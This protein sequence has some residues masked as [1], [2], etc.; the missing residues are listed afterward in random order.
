MKKHLPK[1]LCA[2]FA[3]IFA[4]SAGA[5][6]L[7]FI[8][9]EQEKN[10]FEDLREQIITD[11]PPSSEV[12]SAADTEDDNAVDINELKK[13]NSDAVFWMTIPG[14]NIDYPVM[15]TPASPEEYLHRDFYGKETRSGTP[16]LDG[17]QTADEDNIFIYGHNM[18]N[19]TM[20]WALKKYTSKSFAAENN[21]IYLWAESGLKVYR[22]YAALNTDDGD[23]W[24][25]K[26]E[27]IDEAAYDFAMSYLEG[28]ALYTVGERPE[29]GTK[30]LTLSTCRS[31]GD[32]KRLLVI[33]AQD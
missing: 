15:H 22:I 33:A 31:G 9:G 27:F 6:V 21:K 2:V 16:F 7:Y 23:G 30:L 25:S 19:G 18:K 13:L 5:L 1:I 28:K 29:Y 4:V 12:V 32:N 3:A 14:T 17:Y 10:T 20:F 11:T 8:N 26:R 24:Y